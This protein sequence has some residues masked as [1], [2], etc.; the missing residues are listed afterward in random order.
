MPRQRRAQI[1]SDDLSGARSQYDISATG[2]AEVAESEIEVVP[3]S[4]M[5][6]KAAEES[7]MNE[8]VTILI[9]EDDNPDAPVFVHSGH[10]GRDQYIQRG[11]PQRIK[12]RFLYS[13]IAAKKTAQACS[14]GKDNSG[15]P[16]NRLNGRTNTTHR[17]S[18][19]DDTPQGRAK[20]AEWM[21]QPA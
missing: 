16:F 7:F 9:E 2:D 3:E 13:L 19:I 17:I 20:F 8:E 21:Q 18:V 10:Q 11:V 1:T 15:N 14:F 4:K 12:R 5:M 6:S